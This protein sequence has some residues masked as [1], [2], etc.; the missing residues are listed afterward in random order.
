MATATTRIIK[1]ETILI[2]SHE[3][4][5]FLRDIM[6]TIG[7]SPI[8]T[9]RCFADNIQQALEEVGY[10]SAYPF[11]DMSDGGIYFSEMNTE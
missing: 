5:R 7:G 10:K 1:S 3:E 11:K 2:L 6:E 8:T 4:T 9:R